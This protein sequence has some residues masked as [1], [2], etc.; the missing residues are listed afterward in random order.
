MNQIETKTMEMNSMQQAPDSVVIDIHVPGTDKAAPALARTLHLNGL[1]GLRQLSRESGGPRRKAERKEKD[2]KE[3]QQLIEQAVT[4]QA[5]EQAKDT[6]KKSLMKGFVLGCCATDATKSKTWVLPHHLMVAVVDYLGECLPVITF[7]LMHAQNTV[8]KLRMEWER[9]IIQEYILPGAVPDSYVGHKLGYRHSCIKGYSFQQAQFYFANTMSWPTLHHFDTLSKNNYAGQLPSQLRD[10]IHAFTVSKKFVSKK[11]NNMFHHQVDIHARAMKMPHL[12][13]QLKYQLSFYHNNNLKKSLRDTKLEVLYQT[14]AKHPVHSTT[15]QIARQVVNQRLNNRGEKYQWNTINA[16][17]NGPRSFVKSSTT[18][19]PKCFVR[20]IQT[21]SSMTCVNK[22]F[23]QFMSHSTHWSKEHQTNMLE[24]RRGRAA[25]IQLLEPKIAEFEE[26][27]MVVAAAKVL[28]NQWTKQKYAEKW[29]RFMVMFLLPFLCCLLVFITMASYIEAQGRWADTNT[30]IHNSTIHN[31]TT[32]T[33][34][35]ITEWSDTYSFGVF[36]A[37]AIVFLIMIA[38]ILSQLPILLCPRCRYR[39]MIFYC[40]TLGCSKTCQ[41]IRFASTTENTLRM[42]WNPFGTSLVFF[43]VCLL[44]P[45]M[46]VLRSY[47]W[48]MLTQAEQVGHSPEVLFFPVWPF[49]ILPAFGIPMV[50]VFVWHSYWGGF[51]TEN[52]IGGQRVGDSVLD[53]EKWIAVLLMTLVVLYAAGLI[54]LS[55]KIDSSVLTENVSG[56][57]C[58]LPILIGIGGCLGWTPCQIGRRSD[59]RGWRDDL[60]MCETL[61]YTVF[62]VG[63]NMLV[64]VG[65]PSA[66][67]AM[68]ILQQDYM[69]NVELWVYFIALVL[70]GLAT[71]FFAIAWA[72]TGSCGSS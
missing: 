16:S 52:Y 62:S 64:F 26:K 37:G 15:F 61:Q 6:A 22:Q 12:H 41:A 42:L 2:E 56:L 70:L 58:S 60:T 5:I 51:H 63:V 29:I 54:L 14:M 46:L 31:S 33:F 21:L 34:P 1:S 43:V 72:I 49:F 57:Y 3:V 68:F 44:G 8:S 65:A 67:V 7:G 50:Y 35:G 48:A 66:L 18:K 28:S 19:C 32:A 25:A 55:M 17:V 53:A 11:Y 13:A 9:V 27:K 30:T 59:R 23:C 71:P 10:D 45:F 4:E 36:I 38:C 39:K 47:L 69:V 40:W 24:Y 20:D